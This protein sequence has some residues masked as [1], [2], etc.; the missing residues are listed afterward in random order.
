MSQIDPE[1]AESFNS[2]LSKAEQKM[3]KDY[4]TV[5]NANYLQTFEAV[6]KNSSQE[7]S[8]LNMSHKKLVSLGGGFNDVSAVSPGND[9]GVAHMAVT[10]D[11][12]T[13][14]LYSDGVERQNSLGEVI[15]HELGHGLGEMRGQNNFDTSINMQNTY[16]RSQ[17][18]TYTRQFHGVQKKTHSFLFKLNN[19]F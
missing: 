11:Y 6:D 19:R 1:I 2:S 17:G 9:Y 15:A 13:S 7:G 8:M 14:I 18:K 5:I 16:L 3:L 10:T 12:L 4:V